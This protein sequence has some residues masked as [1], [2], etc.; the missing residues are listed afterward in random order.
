M[1]CGPR[2]LF[3]PLE[4]CKMW[5]ASPDFDDEMT[6]FA[7]ASA[8]FQVFADDQLLCETPVMHPN[9]AWGLHVPLPEGRRQI[10]LVVTDAGD[11]IHGDH[12]DWANAGFLTH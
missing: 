8:V 5:V 6:D 11:G 4:T 10:R 7:P 3:W 9:Q 12:G 2:P 1:L